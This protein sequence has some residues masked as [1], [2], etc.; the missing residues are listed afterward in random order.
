MFT[1]TD[2]PSADGRAGTLELLGPPLGNLFHPLPAVPSLSNS[3]FVE[4]LVHCVCARCV[5]DSGD[6]AMA[7]TEKKDV[8]MI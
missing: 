8:V 7:A 6:W 1:D 2:A 4:H 5:Q 3:A